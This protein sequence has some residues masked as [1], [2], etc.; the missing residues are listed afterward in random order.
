M[1]VKEHKKATTEPIRCKVITVSDTRNE[2]T[3]KSGSLMMAM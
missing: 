2:E 1:S 3:D